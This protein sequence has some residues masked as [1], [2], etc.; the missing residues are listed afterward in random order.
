MR[1]W[2]CGGVRGNDWLN[3]AEVVC[4]FGHLYLWT[5]SF[6]WFLTRGCACVSVDVRLRL[7][8]AEMVCECGRGKCGCAFCAVSC[9]GSVCVFACVFV[10]LC[11]GARVCVCVPLGVHF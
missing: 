4:K 5:S 7:Q 1:A 11:V 6:D 8:C 9:E 3:C 2:S 10:P